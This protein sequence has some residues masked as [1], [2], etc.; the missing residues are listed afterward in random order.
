MCLPILVNFVNVCLS[1][2]EKY[3][4]FFETCVF[5]MKTAIMVLG[6]IF[7][8]P[9]DAPPMLLRPGATAPLPPSVRHC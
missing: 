2:D 8:L 3:F 5:L 9:R 1:C 4:G 7:S 6:N